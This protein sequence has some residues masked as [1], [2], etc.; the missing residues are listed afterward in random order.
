M[1]WVLARWSPLTL[2]SPIQPE[3]KVVFESNFS[4]GFLMSILEDD[5]QDAAGQKTALIA[6][7]QCD[8]LVEVSELEEGSKAFCPRCSHKLQARPKGGVSRPLSLSV[9]ALGLFALSNA[10]PFMS[11]KGAGQ[12][13][14]ITLCHNVMELYRHDSEVLALIV[15]GLV[16]IST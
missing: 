12:E 1:L 14:M 15:F 2:H 9:A 5:G 8:L 4:L 11:F 10:F 7:H 13:Q 3:L 16:V 6:C